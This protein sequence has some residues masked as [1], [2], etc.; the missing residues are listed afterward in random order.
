MPDEAALSRL[1]YELIRGLVE[2]CASPTNF[3][4]AHQLDMTKDDVEGLLRALSEI[5]GVVLH[6]DVCRPWIIHPFSVTPTIHWIRSQ[7]RGWWAPCIWCALGVAVLVGGEVEIHT[8]IAGETEPLTIE[9]V[10]G[11]LFG[12][13]EIWVH[14]AIPPAKAWENVHEHCSL[15]LPFHSPEDVRPWCD[16]HRLPHGEAVPLRQVGHLAQLWYG[17]HADLTWHKW[18][19]AEAQAIFRQVGLQSQFWNLGAKSGKF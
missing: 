2:R 9:I 8:R 13:D 6:P 18:T 14:F 15:I 12:S 11:Q 3:D 1:H 19:V 16:R 17:S 4:L 7:Q 10:E 5:H